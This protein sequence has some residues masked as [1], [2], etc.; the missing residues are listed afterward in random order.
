MTR[1]NFLRRWRRIV[2]SWRRIVE[3]LE[4]NCGEAGG[5]LW[6]NCRRLTKIEVE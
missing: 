5:E 1:V 6:R 3:K 2:E 4:E